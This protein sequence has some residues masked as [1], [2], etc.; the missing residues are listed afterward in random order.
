MTKAASV[1]PLASKRSV[2]TAAWHN[3]AR[4]IL[5][6]DILAVLTAASL[7]WSTS[8]VAV[9]TVLWLLALVPTLNSGAYLRFLNRPACLLP[10][11]FFALAVI[12]NAL[13]RRS[14]ARAPS[15]HQS[16][17]QIT[18]DPSLLY[19]FERSERGAWVFVAFLLCALLMGA[20]LDRMVC[21]GAGS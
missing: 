10:L 11:L 15:W 20:F 6:V 5:A 2:I 17:R 13:G 18:G 4:Q 14:L 8:A 1:A 12:G 19:H 16:R 9:F 3:P 21:T 7:P